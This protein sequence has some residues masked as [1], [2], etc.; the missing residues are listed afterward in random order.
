MK[1]MTFNILHCEDYINEIIDINLFADKIK[2]YGA[3]VCGL[4]EVRGEGPVEGYTDQTNAIGDKL[5]FERYFGQAILVEDTSPYGN[6]IVSRYK[7]SSVETIAVPEPEEET[8]D[9]GY[10]ERCIIKAVTEIDGHSVCF[11]VTHMGL[12]NDERINSVK[13]LCEIIDSTDLPI[14]LMGDFN[15][16]PDDTV[17]IPLF[18]RLKDTDVINGFASKPTYPSDAP[19][20]KIDYILYRGLTCISARTVSEVVSDHL[21]IIAEFEFID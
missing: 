20:I 16:T 14:I 19:E 5:G 17:L 13:T 4:N 15:A 7:F 21:P 9:V 2:S 18:E 1:V 12:A 6:A 11:L 3:D 8:E 10:E